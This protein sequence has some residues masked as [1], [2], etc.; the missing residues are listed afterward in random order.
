MHA[1]TG[2]SGPRNGPPLEE[3]A[4]G[5]ADTIGGHG[6][7]ARV[8][9]LE[10]ADV[11]RDRRGDLPGENEGRADLHPGHLHGPGSGLSECS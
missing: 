3:A 11:V 10:L 5:G 9:L 8:V 1:Y 2:A 6:H 4:P 7:D